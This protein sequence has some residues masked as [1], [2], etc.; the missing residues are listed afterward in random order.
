MVNEKNHLYG[1]EDAL[2]DSKQI[3]KRRTQQGFSRFSTASSF[4]LNSNQQ[5]AVSPATQG[6]TKPQI[7][8]PYNDTYGTVS[9]TVPIQLNL[10]GSTYSI[11]KINGNTTFQ[12]NGLPLG[13]HIKFTIEFTVITAT[14][15]TI[16]FPSELINP[17]TLPALI[18]NLTVILNFEGVVDENGEVFTYIGGTSAEGVVA[19]AT[20]LGTLTGNFVVDFNTFD[21]RNLTANI[22]AASVAITF[23]NATT[24]MRLHMRI[25]LLTVN[26]TL[27]IGGQTIDDGTKPW[28]ANDF[29]DID[30]RFDPVPTAII[31]V[32]KK[33]NDLGGGGIAPGLPT[34]AFAIGNSATTIKVSYG[35][36]PTGT[37]PITYDIAWSLSPTETGGGGPLTPA[38]GSPTTGI[39]TPTHEITG[40]TAATTYY[41]W[42][43]AVNVIGTSLYVGPLQTNTDGTANPGGVNFAIPGASVLFNS[44]TCTWDQPGAL[45][46]T[47]TRTNPNGEVI[48]LQDFS[49]ADVDIVDNQ[50]IDPATAYIYRLTTYNEF[51]VTLGTQTINVNSAAIPAPST[52]LSAVGTKLR[53]AVTFPIGFSLAEVEWSINSG[54]TAPTTT[55]DFGRPLGDW[56]VQSTEDFD[57]Q[58]LTPSTTYFGRVRFKVNGAT[59]PFGNTAPTSIATSGLSV[60]ATPGIGNLTSPGTG[61]V[62]MRVRFNNGT[63]T[64]EWIV[65]GW[66]LENTIGPYTAFETYFRDNPP[67]DDIDFAQ[68]DR[69]EV[70]RQ[71]DGTPW[72]I[73]KGVLL[74]FRAECFNASGSN[75]IAVTD[76][77]TLDN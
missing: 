6:I 47:L 23:T 55:S 4:A 25:Y 21:D 76:N 8:T 49:T 18:N 61:Q 29:L 41:V 33:N 39:S 14:P 17:P 28:V 12:F 13:R 26:P 66:R 58:F 67:A 50:G 20:D 9:G 15:P 45:I 31:E 2:H 7:G 24:A 34:G 36:P 59:G 22:N 40:L 75:G 51:R 11:M 48:T 71:A 5:N 46:F 77:V 43:R 64:G 52:V 53:F 1:P 65:V 42:V 60:P 69:I 63:S 32:V 16:T 74:T 44:I 27:T 19:K 57:T 35:Q 30:L 10:F 38:A 54:F 3:A 68:E 72:N 37:L 70:I 56:S 73:P 62:R